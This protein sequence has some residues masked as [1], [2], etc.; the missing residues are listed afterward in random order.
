MIFSGTTIVKGRCH[1]IVVETGQN[2]EIGKIASLIQEE[3][4]ATP[5]QKQLKSVG[6]RS[7]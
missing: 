3:E 7:E 5:L 6:K 1:A 4:E 2:T